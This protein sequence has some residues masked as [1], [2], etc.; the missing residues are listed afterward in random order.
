[1]QYSPKSLHLNIHLLQAGLSRNSSENAKG[2]QA[3]SPGCEGGYLSEQRFGSIWGILGQ[4][5]R[6]NPSRACSTLACSPS[7][8]HP[9]ITGHPTPGAGPEKVF[10]AKLIK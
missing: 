7:L 3:Q 9:K 10:G 8:S 4:K 1:M 6:R 2:I 5:S